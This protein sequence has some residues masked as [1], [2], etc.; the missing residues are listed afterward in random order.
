MQIDLNKSAHVF[1]SYV[2]KGYIAIVGLLYS[3]GKLLHKHLIM[4]PLY[5]D[6]EQTFISYIVQYYQSNQLPKELIMPYGLNLEALNEVLETKILQP[7]RGEKKKLIELAIENAKIHLEQN[8]EVASKQEQLNETA[9]QQLKDLIQCNTTRIELYDISHTAGEAA[10]GAQVVY[11]DGLASKKDYRLYKVSNKNNDFANMQ[12][13]IYRRLF[14]AKKNK[15][16]LPDIIIVDGAKSQ[17]KAA[18]EILEALDISSICLLGLTKDERHQTSALMNDSFE[19]YDLDKESEL[20][21]LLTNMQDEV[22]RFTISYHKRLRERKFKESILDEIENIGIKR[23]EKLLSHFKTINR[24]KSASLQQLA[25]V[26]GHKS[27]QAVYDFFGKE[28]ED[29]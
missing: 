14:N 3:Q 17:I 23:K 1:A 18:K 21:Y 15:T 7:Q 8:F 22:H 19:I 26:I 12:E 20:F 4:K 28:K 2:D 9:L 25:E 27:G 24:I 10:V 13:V 6:T 11:V 29:V 5:D 16:V